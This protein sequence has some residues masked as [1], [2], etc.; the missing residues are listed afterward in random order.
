M[1]ES[2]TFRPARMSAQLKKLQSDFS[3]IPAQY[4]TQAIAIKNINESIASMQGSLAKQGEMLTK[5]T[6]AKKTYRHKIRKIPPFILVSID[7][8]G[9]DLTA[10]VR[11]QT[12]LQELRQGQ[13]LSQWRVKSIDVRN[14]TV[15]FSHS[16]GD[17]KTLHISS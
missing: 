7:Q 15:T 2:M 8:W 3:K 11:H 17:S 13:A 4:D 1:I 12:Q 14:S 5:K 6:K 10:I 16:A 9:N